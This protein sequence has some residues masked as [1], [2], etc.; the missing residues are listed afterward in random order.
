MIL[1]NLILFLQPELYFNE[2]PLTIDLNFFVFTFL[3]SVSK[4]KHKIADQNLQLNL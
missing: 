4:W 3:P 1:N 2:N